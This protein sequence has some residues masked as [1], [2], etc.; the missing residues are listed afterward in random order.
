MRVNESTVRQRLLELAPQLAHVDVDRPV[1]SAK[2]APP[3]GHV[4]LRAGYD[5]AEAPGQRDEEF[6]LAHGQR[7]RP[8]GREDQPFLQSDLELAG[9]ED[10]SLDV[11]A[12]RKGR[13]D[14]GRATLGGSRSSKLLIYR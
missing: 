1:G 14:A 3:D 13:N 8:A 9:V 7:Q 11:R 4:E 2:R 10:V 5:R 6:E 12:L